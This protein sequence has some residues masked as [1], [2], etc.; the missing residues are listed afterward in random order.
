MG[1]KEA[2]KRLT[3]EGEKQREDVFEWGDEADPV[4]EPPTLTGAVCQKVDEWVGIMTE[5]GSWFD[6]TKQNN[7][8]LRIVIPGEISRDM[9]PATLS[10]IT[11]DEDGNPRK[12]EIDKE[13]MVKTS[14]A[15]LCLGLALEELNHRVVEDIDTGDFSGDSKRYLR[16]ILR[17]YPCKQMSESWTPKPGW[18]RERLR[19]LRPESTGTEEQLIII[20]KTLCK[21]FVRNPDQ[22]EQGKFAAI[23]PSTKS[24]SYNDVLNEFIEELSLDKEQIVKKIRE[25]IEKLNQK[26]ATV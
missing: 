15:V 24:F 2:D 10:P 4:P 14:V 11:F 22:R 8:K 9:N 23:A 13:S 21:Y 12:V 5:P 7:G 6:W 18:K 16:S 20:Q 26:A 19:Q 17:H 3:K 1:N 25:S